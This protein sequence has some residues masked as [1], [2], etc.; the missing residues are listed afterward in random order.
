MTSVTVNGVPAATVARDADKLVVTPAAGIDNGSTFDA[1]VAYNGVPE[2]IQ[3]PDDSLEG[4]LR[5]RRRR[6]RGQRADGRHGLVPEQQPPDTTRRR[7]TSRSPCRPARSRS[8]T[9]SSSPRPT[10][11]T[12]RRRGTGTM[13]FPMATYLS[14]ATVGDFD[15][16]RGRRRDRARRLRLAAQALQRDRQLLHQTTKNGQHATFAREDAIVKYFSGHLRAVPVRLGRRGRRPGLG[17]RLRARGADEDPLPEQRRRRHQRQHALARDR[18][19]VV[20]QQRLAEAVERHL[21]QRGLGDVVAVELVEQ[22]TTARSRRRSSSTNNYNSTQQPTRWNIAD[23]GRCRPR[24]NLFNTFPVYTRGAMT[25]EGLRQI[26]GD[27]AFF[28]LALKTWMTEHRYGNA[29]TAD[30]IALAKRIAARQGGLRGLEPRQAGHVLPAVAYTPSKP[31]M[32]PTTFFQRTDAPGGVS[33]TVPAD[34]GAGGRRRPRRSA[35]SP[36]AWRATTR[37]RRPPTSSRRPATRR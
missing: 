1:V 12:A 33:G 9:A 15:L 22:G 3:D 24:P 17:R 34:A 21:A 23:R 20:R 5:R 16:T 13:D 31:T 25:I 37:R 18:A 10:T 11:R 14:T 6:V 32:T 4:W 36:R 8:A 29:G 35:R 2:Q 27:D 30:F 26:L 28:A 19:P 7:T